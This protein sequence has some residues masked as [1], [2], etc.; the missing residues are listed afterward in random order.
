MNPNEVPQ[1]KNPFWDSFCQESLH[2][3]E[4]QWVPLGS[5]S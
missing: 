4:G 2:S 3:K 1:K 5:V